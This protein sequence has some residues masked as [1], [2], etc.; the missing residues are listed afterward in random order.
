MTKP[1]QALWSKYGLERVG[2][3]SE[4]IFRFYSGGLLV[5]CHKAKIVSLTV[6]KSDLRSPDCKL[7]MATI[8]FEGYDRHGVTYI[9][10]DRSFYIDDIWFFNRK[11]L[12]KAALSLNLQ[13]SAW[14]YLKQEGAYNN[15]CNKNYPL[16][17]DSVGSY[18]DGESFH[19]PNVHLT[20]FKV[21]LTIA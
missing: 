12:V 21:N 9:G 19:L 1:H 20:E 4:D 8:S 13:S 14:D 3:E 17:I 15:V 10:E 11:T 7:M 5:L 6:T 16:T 18:V 2:D